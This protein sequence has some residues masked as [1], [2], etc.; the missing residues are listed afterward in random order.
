MRSMP[1]LFLASA[2][3]KQL[4]ALVSGG[5]LRFKE[6]LVGGEDMGQSYLVK[7]SPTRGGS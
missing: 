2:A 7:L 4:I 5:C 6:L 1:I 3:K